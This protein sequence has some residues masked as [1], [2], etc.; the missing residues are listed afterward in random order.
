MIRSVTSSIFTSDAK[1]LVNPVNTDGVMG[2]GLALAFKDRYPRLIDPYRWAC[3]DGILDV[4]RPFLWKNPDESRYVLCFATKIHW[5][6]PSKIEWVDQGLQ[7]IA[8]HHRT[9]PFRTIAMPLLG[10]GLGGLNS[11]DVLA[12]IYERLANTS[13]EVIVHLPSEA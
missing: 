6:L 8:D 9:Y 7:Y 4:G 1:C 12:L 11:E 13:L 5:R 2:A 10:C 3:R